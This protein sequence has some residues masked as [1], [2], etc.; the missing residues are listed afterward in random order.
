M[1]I[2]KAQQKSEELTQKATVAPVV[3]QPMAVHS[4]VEPL[5]AAAMEQAP[6]EQVPQDLIEKA[7]AQ[8]APA[9]PPEPAAAATAAP[10]ALPEEQPAPPSTDAKSS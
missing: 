4:I 7:I 6:V 8:Q 3:E 10:T 2:M 1:A 5:P 9:G